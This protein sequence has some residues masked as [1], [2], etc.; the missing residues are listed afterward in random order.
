MCCKTNNTE[1]ALELC[2]LIEADNFDTS[3][4]LLACTIDLMTKTKNVNNAEIAFAKL[5]S[6]F[7]KF[8]IDSYKIVDLATLLVQNNRLDDS[9]QLLKTN[10]KTSLGNNKY[11]S[12]NVWRFLM[13]VAEWSIKNKRIENVT[14]I[15]LNTLVELGYCNYSNTHLGP[16]IREHIDKNEIEMAVDA[17]E[18]LSEKHRKTPQ[19]V[20]LMSQL[21]KI[22]NDEQS[23]INGTKSNELLKRVVTACRKVHGDG[24]TNTNL[25]TAFAISGTEQQLRKLLMNPTVK[26]VSEKMNKNL[27]HLSNNN[28]VEIIMKLAK[29]CRGIRNETIDE[30]SLYQTL[31]NGFVRENN[32]QSAIEFFK[33]ISMDEGSKISQ[34][35]LQTL[36]DLLEKNKQEIPTEIRLKIYSKA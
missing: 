5:K 10:W 16:V 11:I 3:P 24:S 13:E 25:L 20:V 17:F 34:K 21:I 30:Q 27:E 2:K 1:R 8:H 12:V 19:Q 32:W 28:K 14:E 36:V 4:A 26:V 22:S 35:L 9:L 33:E 18:R 29:C 23:P 6:R 31:L 15:V 7:P